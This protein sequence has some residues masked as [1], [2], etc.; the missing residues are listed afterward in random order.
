MKTVWFSSGIH[1]SNSA[2]FFSHCMVA[3]ACPRFIR[4][5]FQPPGA[6]LRTG[7]RYPF[8]HSL[9]PSEVQCSSSSGLRTPR[10]FSPQIGVHLGKQLLIAHPVAAQRLYFRPGHEL[11]AIQFTD[12]PLKGLLSSKGV[13]SY[14]SRNR[15]S[16]DDAKND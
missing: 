16:S 8:D 6:R 3:L 4:I 12:C 10:V 5:L 11:P 13:K 14:N 7:R 9:L 1:T 2:K 15:D